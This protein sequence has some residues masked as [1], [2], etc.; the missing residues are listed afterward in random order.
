MCPLMCRGVPTNVPV[1][2]SAVPANF[3]GVPTNVPTNRFRRCARYG[4][5]MVYPSVCP[6]CVPA[7]FKYCFT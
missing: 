4:L 1:N 5:P 3:R 6:L 7:I 2:V